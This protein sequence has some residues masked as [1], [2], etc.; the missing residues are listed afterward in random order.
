MMH[1]LI[2]VFFIFSFL[3]S[4]SIASAQMP[5]APLPG[6]QPQPR[7]I[8]P[9]E[10]AL[11]NF[12]Q[13]N[14]DQMAVFKNLLETRQQTMR[15]LAERFAELE[16]RWR[17][18]FASANPDPVIAGRLTVQMHSIRQQMN[19]VQRQFIQDFEDLLMPDQKGRLQLL[20]MAVRL[21][22][23]VNALRPLLF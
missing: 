11:E 1:K 19:R 21:E 18:L 17:G 23:T 7:P 10:K 14:E 8:Q 6:P 2:V 9:P 16:K 5:P 12:F 4:F 3:L 13:L 20:R 15:P 22:P